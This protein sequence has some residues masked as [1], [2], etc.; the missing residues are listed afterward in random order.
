MEAL[1]ES[2]Q[3]ADIQWLAGDPGGWSANTIMLEGCF[4]FEMGFTLRR[5]IILMVQE[6]ITKCCIR[7]I[8]PT[9]RFWERWVSCH[10]SDLIAN[11]GYSQ[12]IV[13]ALNMITKRSLE[14]ILSRQIGGPTTH[15]LTIDNVQPE[16][17]LRRI[18]STITHL[19][20]GLQPKTTIAI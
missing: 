6:N 1:E 7:P 5:R 11:A 19:K 8:G 9:S 4:H 16:V 15:L 20:L 13:I 2:V 3:D 10:K 17:D 12:W 18:E 14:I